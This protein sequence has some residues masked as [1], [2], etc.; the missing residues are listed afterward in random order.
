MPWARR[1][2]SAVVQAPRSQRYRMDECIGIGAFGSVHRGYDA[3]LEREVAIKVPHCAPGSGLGDALWEEARALARVSHPNVVGVYDIASLDSI[4]MIDP[5]SDSS[6]IPIMVMEFVE[7][8][9]LHEWI[10]EH[11]PSL[12]RTLA[13]FTQVASGLVATHEHGVVHGDVKLSNMV[14]GADGRVRLLDFGFASSLGSRIGGTERAFMGSPG[15]MAPELLES[16]FFDERSDQYAFGTSVYYALYG[17]LPFFGLSISELTYV[18]KANAPGFLDRSDTRGRLEDLL[19]R[20]LAA[21]PEG[22]FSSM[23][24]VRDELRWILRRMSSPA[25]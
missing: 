6:S 1:W 3:N 4:G 11:R 19:R 10:R 25:Q 2:N 16:R 17:R 5:D 15:Y 18:K 9:P 7:G 22:R 13:L 21:E 20:C 12:A 23:R 14:L 24:E 8:W